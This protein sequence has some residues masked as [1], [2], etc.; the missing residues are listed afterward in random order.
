MGSGA[1][2]RRCVWARLLC[3][4]LAPPVGAGGGGATGGNE[5]QA[6]SAEEP[7]APT[8]QPAHEPVH[9]PH[10]RA[11]KPFHQEGGG[12]RLKDGRQS[13]KPAREHEHTHH[14]EQCPR[15]AIHQPQILL[16][17]LKESQEML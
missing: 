7:R 14:N 6:G 16:E 11:L 8:Y 9:E 15:E 13:L 12:E 17:L 4:L 3:A 2:G 5:Q 1:S 10:S